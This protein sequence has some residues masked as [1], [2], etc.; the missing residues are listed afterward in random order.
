VKPFLVFQNGQTYTKEQ[1]D[2]IANTYAEELRQCGYD[3]TCRIGV[4]SNIENVFKL[5]GAMQVCSPVIVDHT[6]TKTELDFYDIDI[7]N[8][9]LPEPRFNQC[10]TDEVVGICSSG[11]T[12]TPRI[13]PLTEKQ[14]HVDGLDVN[15]QL[16]GKITQDDITVNCI[17][18]WVCIGFQTFALCYKTGATYY[19]LDNPWIDWPTVN[20][21][22][23]IG[24]PNVLNKLMQTP[25]P[26]KNMTVRHIRTVGAPMYKD[27]KI[28]AQQYFNCITTDSYGVNEIGTI[29]IMHYP[30]KY[31]SVG[32]VLDN[33]DC[34]I[35]DGEIIA[36]GF[37]TGDLGHIDADGFLFITGRKKETI[38][39]GGWKIM[40]YEVE[41]ALL[42]S[43]ATDAVVF[44]YDNVYAEV[45]GTVNKELLKSKLAFY[46]IPKEI[47]YVDSIT[48]KR[49]GKIN[50][51]ELLNSY[52]L[53][54]KI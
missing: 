52:K 22:F 20:P 3:K 23:F 43:G 4:Y 14:Y 53:N 46:K 32:Y 17:P 29:S 27:L 39:A 8:Q 50:R 12:E 49:Q 11:S 2:N 34:K 45:V 15:I 38:I 6:L 35:V 40:P 10:N 26:Y 16:H 33:I 24:S 25:V 13:I 42:E 41:K 7:W 21:T 31:N 51:K 48:R 9:E 37:A 36:N 19:V 18:L 54:N 44:G 28:K 1:F 5:F 30:Q 47:F